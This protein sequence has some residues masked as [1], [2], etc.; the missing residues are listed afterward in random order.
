MRR[1]FFGTILLVLSFLLSATS[2]SAG[3]VGS[4]GIRPSIRYW[5]SDAGTLKPAPSP[6]PVRTEPQLL[7][8]MYHNIV[9]GRTGNVYNRDLYNFEYDLQALR[10]NYT[11][12]DFSELFYT[13]ATDSANTDQAI[14]TFDD[15]DLSIYALAFPLLKEYG[16]KA[17]FFLVPSYVGTVGY[18]SWDQIREMAQ[19][20]DAQGRRLF[21]FGSHSMNHKRLGNLTE[22]EIR[23]E[24]SESKRIIEKE[25]GYPVRVLALPFGSGAGDERIIR[26]ARELGY[27]AIRTSVPRAEKLDELDL[28]NLGGFNVE[29]YSTDKF[30]ENIIALSGR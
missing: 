5:R 14:L 6:P 12:T 11:I 24:L 7:V 30:V 3:S 13:L 17:T 27:R 4:D 2:V 16:M 22:Q 21:Y 8:V 25:T 18:M 1:F 20:R 29:N 10:R 28:M 23:K 9:Y 19:Y 15:G 26:I